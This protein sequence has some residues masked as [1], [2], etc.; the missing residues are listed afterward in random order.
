MVSFRSTAMG[1]ASASYSVAQLAARP[2][3]DAST[4]RCCVFREAFA[5]ESLELPLDR[6]ERPTADVPLDPPEV[7]A[8]EREDEALH[9]EDEEDSDASEQGPREVGVVDPV[10]DPPATERERQQRGDRP[11]QKADP[12]DRLRPEA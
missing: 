2:H 1:T 7:L 4:F 10:H 9:A 3:R 8:N 5:P 6:V 12:L 11:E